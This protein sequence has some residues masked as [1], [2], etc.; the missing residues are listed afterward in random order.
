MTDPGK[1]SLTPEELEARVEG[2]KGLTAKQRGQL[3][4]IFWKEQD[5]ADRVHNIREVPFAYTAIEARAEAVRCLTCKNEPCVTGCPVAVDVPGFLKLVAEGDFRGAIRLIKETNL[6]PAICG[7][8]CPQES[9]CQ[10]N[11]MVAKVHK[12]LGFAVS[13]GKI[14]AF[15]ADW[16]R[17]EGGVELPAVGAP[18][19]K[20][21]AIIGAGPS[22]LTCAGDLRRLG[23]EAVIFE[24]FHKAGG[25]LV[26]G[27]PEFRL[28]KDIVEA[29]VDNLR[30]MGVAFEFDT[31]IGQTM[32]VDDL[33]DDGFDA[34]YVAT[35]AGLPY[36]VNVPGE[37]LNG[38]YSANEYL[39]RA[40]LMGAYR[41]PEED[42]PVLRRDNVAVLGGG[43]VAMDAARTAL[44]LGAKNV[45]LVYRRS[46]DEM[47]ARLEEVHHAEEEGVQFRM[48]SAPVEILSTDKGWVR[49][50]KI[51]K[52]ELGEPD[53]KGRRRPLPIEGAYEEL[54]VEIVIEAIGNGPNPLIPKTTAGLTT[55]RHGTLVVDEAT[56]MTTRKGVFAGGDIVAG[57]S[58]VILAMGHG[59]KAAAA[60]DAYLKNE[61]AQPAAFDAT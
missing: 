18:T 10:E 14:E 35:G 13:V 12:D 60:I 56:M 20:R 45:F 57:A 1:P 24:A 33:F 36:F 4:K 59:R 19:G 39:T 48:L 55:T 51:Q 58:T 27:I 37:D 54:P 3:P 2:R 49:A 8:V 29:E 6:L 43:N 41:F 31:V 44:R 47:P 25:V 26:Y 23:H 42:T 21:V 46:R 7:R 34:V 11:C 17:E 5:A 53:E 28:P 61:S 16:E 40:N 50:L 30:Q 22:G 32:T 52:C 15:L 38:V 9:Q